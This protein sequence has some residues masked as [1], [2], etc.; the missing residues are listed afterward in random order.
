MEKEGK[1][2]LY[3]FVLFLSF[4]RVVFVKKSVIEKVKDKKEKRRG[5]GG[6]K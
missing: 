1:N 3:Y 4:V 2:M 5:R 6:L